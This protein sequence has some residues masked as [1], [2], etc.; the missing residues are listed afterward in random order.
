MPITYKSFKSQTFLSAIQGAYIRG[1]LTFGEL[2]LRGN[3]VLISAYQEFKINYYSHQIS[4]S[5]QGQAVNVKVLGCSLLVLFLDVLYHNE[6]KNANKS[7]LL[8]NEKVH[9]QK[10]NERFRRQNSP[11]K[12]N[13]FLK[14]VGFN[15]RKNVFLPPQFFHLLHFQ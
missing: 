13:N 5:Q 14:S 3:V 8:D 7:N 15:G 12:D 11:Q 9:R 10:P 1:G 4:I 6:V 2:I